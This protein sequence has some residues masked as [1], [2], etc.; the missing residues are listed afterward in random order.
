MARMGGKVGLVP[1]QVSVADLPQWRRLL[2][3]QAG[4]VDTSQLASFGVSADVIRANVEGG[5]WAPVLPRVYSTATGPLTRNARIHAALRYAGP[6]VLLSHRTAAEEW[7]LLAI[8]DGPVHVT[9]PY[10]CSAVSQPPDVVVH[11][12]RAFAH[13]A[14]ATAPP[15][16]SRADTVIDTAAG[17]PT[18]RDAMR[19]LVGLVTSST[20]S[21]LE[22]ERR[23]VERP[24]HRYRRALTSALRRMGDGVDSALE[25]LFVRDVEQAHGLPAAVRQAPFVVDGRLFWEDMVYDHVGVA[26]TVRLDGRHHTLPKVAFRDRRRDNAA[27][28]AGRAR[29]AF[30]WSDVSKDPCGVTGE[31]DA[32]LRRAGWQ[33]PLRRCPRCS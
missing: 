13:L 32:V 17:E 14:V 3:E 11:R 20:V 8:S 24:P 1:A 5:R 29:L 16:T 25:D 9:V 6:T 23:L 28:L 18:A 12:S 4:I 10:G 27:E 7:G 19:C 26:L 21:L 22:I 15:R 31:V 30:G 2:E 33:G